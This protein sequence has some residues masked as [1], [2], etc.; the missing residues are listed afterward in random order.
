MMT[1]HVLGRPAVD[2]LDIAQCPM[3]T[4]EAVWIDLFEPT[5]EE[6]KTVEAALGIDVPTREHMQEIESSSRLRRENGVLFMTSQVLSQSDTMAPASTAITFILDTKQRLVTVRYAEPAPFRTVRI[7]R[8]T[9]TEK[10]GS[11]QAIL[12]AL[13][14][15]IVDRLADILETVGTK[16]DEISSE[17]FGTKPPAATALL[18]V[19]PQANGAAKASARNAGQ[20]PNYRD[21]LV[22]IGR[23]NDLISKVRESGVGLGRVISFLQEDRK[24]VAVAGAKELGSHLKTVGADLGSLGDHTSYLS[25]KANFLLDTTLG[26]IN[27]EQNGIIKIFSVAAVVLLPPTLVAS[28][29]GMNFEIMPELKWVFGY[30]FAVALMAA[31]AIVPYLLF[32]KKGWL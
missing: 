29:Y 30:P 1:F 31:S 19:P 2:C 10:L 26:L 18:G 12:E 23:C 21:V 4:N 28:V 6:E 13:I 20:G 9:E 17:L 22:R 24:K 8:D 3:L 7:H 32:K 14:D 25:S 16:L 27:I 5:K 15:A 11:G